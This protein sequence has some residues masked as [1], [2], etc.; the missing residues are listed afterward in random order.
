MISVNPDWAHLGELATGVGTLL[1]IGYNAYQ[2][3]RAKKQ[4]DT[5]HSE[6]LNAINK[7]EGTEK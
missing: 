4:L 3:A 7:P 6:T 1:G 5:V 2:N